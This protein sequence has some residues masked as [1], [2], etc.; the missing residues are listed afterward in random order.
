MLTLDASLR[1]YDLAT[2]ADQA[3][4][5]E[6]LGFG[7]IWTQ[8][9][10]HDPFLPLAAAAIVTTRI[11]LGTSIAVAF[12][13]SPM[14]LAYT[15]WDLQKASRGRFIL[16]LGS[17]VK[18]H[19]E[20]R[21]S[22]KYESPGPRLREVVLALRAIWAAW[23][24][25]TPLDFRGSFYRFDLMTPFFDP[26][27]IEHPRIPIFVAGVNQYM[28]RMAGEVADGLHV[29]PFHTPKYLR[30][31]VHPAVE[32]GLQS[33]GRARADFSM[34][35]ATFAIV[36]DTEAERSRAAEAVRRQIAFYASTRTYEP[37]LATHGW[38]RVLPE[39]HRKSL[40]KDWD[41]MSSLITDEMLATFAVS[42]TLE[43]IAAQLRDRYAGRLLDRTALY[44]VGAPQHDAARLR[45]LITA[46][47]RIN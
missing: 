35:S 8:E 23:Q 5:L 1:S 11:R 32:K 47:L 24:D 12:P 27:P 4:Q 31:Y 44:E 36:G 17:Q 38:E 15:A 3:R 18:A 42:G 7:A 41:G 22:V 25:R 19:N 2:V 9:T 46:G 40:A 43:Q 20:R 16:G 13:R 26:G 29:H 14:V 21:F 33:S 6:D 28:C 30:K 45:S 34:V 10:Q 37:V 39:L